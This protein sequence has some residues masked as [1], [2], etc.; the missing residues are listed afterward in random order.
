MSNWKS[1]K[2]RLFIPEGFEP[3][4]PPETLPVTERQVVSDFC[5]KMSPTDAKRGAKRRKNK[6]GGGS[7]STVCSTSGKA[8]VSATDLSLQATA[9]PVSTMGFLTSGSSGNGNMG[10][11]TGLN[12]E[13][14][15][16]LTC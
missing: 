7:S 3:D 13:V 16:Q 12:G 6:R 9:T 14:N 11:I 10:S 8:G 2:Y 1:L 15:I 4:I 5:G